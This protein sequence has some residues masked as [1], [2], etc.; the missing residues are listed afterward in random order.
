MKEKLLTFYRRL[1][2]WA[3]LGWARH[4]WS[5]DSHREC[6]LLDREQLSGWTSWSRRWRLTGRRSNFR[7]GT[8]PDRRG[9]GASPSPTTDPHTPSS[10]ST[11]WPISQRSTV[12]PTG[13]G[14]SR[15]TRRPRCW[16]SWWET[17][18]TGTIMRSPLMLARSSLTDMECISYRYSAISIHKINSYLIPNLPLDFG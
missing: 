17:R 1:C 16:G 10:W 5:E 12:V 8:Q 7:S 13:C 15:S 6:F 9:S 2:W 3:M 11:T 4:V 18:S 14:R